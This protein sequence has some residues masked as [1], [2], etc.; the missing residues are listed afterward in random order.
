MRTS[1]H[2]FKSSYFRHTS[3][4]DSLKSTNSRN[5]TRRMANHKLKSFR[6]STMLIWKTT[7]TLRSRVWMSKF[8]SMLSQLSKTFKKNLNPTL[9]MRWKTAQSWSSK[10]ANRYF[11][12]QMI[13]SK[14][15]SRQI[16]SPKTG[17]SFVND[18]SLRCEFKSTRIRLSHVTKHWRDSLNFSALRKNTQT[19]LSLILVIGTCFSVFVN[20]KS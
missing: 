3:N 15:K 5:F 14:T 8:K 17:A 20:S 19:L 13:I 16:F 11:F 6:S 12:K 18:G 4:T 9:T 10:S 2:T 1:I 7:S